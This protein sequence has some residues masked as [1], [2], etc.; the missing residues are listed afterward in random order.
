MSNWF[1]LGE[2]AFSFFLSLLVAICLIDLNTNKLQNLIGIPILL[3]AIFT[4]FTVFQQAF[5]I[6]SWCK[7][8]M[9]ISVVI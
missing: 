8:C 7:M 4:F 1:G 3:G 9:V 2:L 6:K 5:I